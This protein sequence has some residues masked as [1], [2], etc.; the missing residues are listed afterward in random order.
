FR[1]PRKFLTPSIHCGDNPFVV[2]SLEANHFHR[3]LRCSMALTTVLL[4]GG[5]C[6]DIKPSHGE[7]IRS[8]IAVTD[9]QMRLSAR[10]LGNPARGE[11]ENTADA[12]FDSTKDIN[13]Q[14]AALSWKI[15][16]VPQM[17]E[18]LFQPNP[19]IA[20]VDALAMCNQ[21]A[22]FFEKGAGKDQ[23]GAAAPEAVAC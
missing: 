7:K 17:R 14:L 4:F 8:I 6:V 23:L 16:A 3:S 13:L 11:I 20:A 12:I 15:D 5:G 2:M 1:F 19:Y 21:M 9:N 22:D 10:R 18:A